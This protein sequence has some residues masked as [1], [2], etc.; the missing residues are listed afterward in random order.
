M[1]KKKTLHLD[2]KKRVTLGK[3]IS[4]E[5]TFFEVEKRADGILVFYPKSELSQ[6]EIWVYKN[7]SAY[8]ALKLGLKDLKKGLVTKIEPEFW[9]GNKEIINDFKYTKEF[10]QKL[11][12]IISKNDSQKLNKI[13]TTLEKIAENK[14]EK[15]TLQNIKTDD[16]SDIY[17]A[18]TED[19]FNIFWTEKND[20]KVI[21]NLIKNT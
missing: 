15:T 8:K 1:K 14:I 18:K 19:K 17:Q 12:P 2:G 6:D 3:L 20:F 10:L 21:I 9:D 16:N 7:K 5:T 11:E 4:K 13:K